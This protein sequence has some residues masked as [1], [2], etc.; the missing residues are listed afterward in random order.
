MR[1]QRFAIAIGVVILAL[2]GFGSGAGADD[3]PPLDDIPDNVSQH[4]HSTQAGVLWRFDEPSGW[5][6]LSISAVDEFIVAPK[7]LKWQNETVCVFI[8][9][10]DESNA[11]NR[12]EAAAGC[13]PLG[14]GEYDIDPRLVDAFVKTTVPV[15]CYVFLHCV[16]LPSAV[17]VDLSWTGGGSLIVG[18]GNSSGT[19]CHIFGWGERREAMDVRGSVS[20]GVTDYTRGVVG[21]GEM[22]RGIRTALIVGEPTDCS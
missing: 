13:K 12:F 16:T 11:E 18:H 6:Q 5:T 9:H 2:A 22:D 8:S 3:V 20:D 10:L 19:A 1:C 15:P 21:A 7:G 17:N 14:K 4:H